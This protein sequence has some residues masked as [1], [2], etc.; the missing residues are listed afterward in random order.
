MTTKNQNS[1]E[2]TEQKIVTS[3]TFLNPLF[4]AKMSLD[5][6]DQEFID[7][8][9]GG[10]LKEGK[11]P[12]K[13]ISQTVLNYGIKHGFIFD[14]D[15]L[16]VKTDKILSELDKI[17]STYFGLLRIADKLA[18]SIYN[19]ADEI[20]L[21]FKSK[22]GDKMPVKGKG[23]FSENSILGQCYEVLLSIDT[24]DEEVFKSKVY[25]IQ[26]KEKGVLIPISDTQLGKYYKD[27][28]NH[29]HSIQAV[30]EKHSSDKFMSFYQ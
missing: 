3:H 25:E 29:I 4:K 17:P 26:R 12:L 5:D 30:I 9:Y 1:E 10:L 28:V 8:S 21:S 14:Q 20:M 11:I 18:E 13:L 24:L 7:A 15:K 2:T 22:L 27:M 19:S 16:L 6:I 23:Y